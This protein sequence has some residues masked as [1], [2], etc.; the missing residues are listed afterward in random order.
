[1]LFRRASK[2]SLNQIHNNK[3]K[4]IT[5]PAATSPL[6]A[7][8]ELPQPLPSLGDKKVLLKKAKPGLKEMIYLSPLAEEQGAH[9]EALRS[10]SSSEGHPVTA[11]TFFQRKKIPGM[12]TESFE[13]DEAS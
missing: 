7:A 3:P 2:K 12:V 4:D 6:C 5:R 10:W 11:N 1:M 8:P 9:E 13:M